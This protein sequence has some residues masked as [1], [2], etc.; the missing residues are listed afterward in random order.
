MTEHEHSWLLYWVDT[1]N[2]ETTEHFK[3]EGCD[4]KKESKK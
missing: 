3:C 1:Y 2:G 4:K